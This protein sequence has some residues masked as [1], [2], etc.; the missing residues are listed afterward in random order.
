M[1]HPDLPLE[2]RDDDSGSV[3]EVL[4]IAFPLIMA[5]SSHALRLFSDRLMLSRFSQESLSASLSAGVM[6]FAS[7]CFFMGTASYAGTFVA[8]YTGAGRSG[9]VGASVWQGIYLALF[10]GLCLAM[11]STQAHAIFAWVGHSP[12]VQVQQVYY[13]RILASMAV[14]PLLTG[15]IMCFWSG[16]GR[17]WTIFLISSSGVAINIFF[18]WL[19]IFGNWGFPELGIR[20][21]AIATDISSVF[22]LCFALT[23][24]WAK[25]NRK[26][27]ET[28]PRKTF[29]WSLFSRLVRFGVP[30]GVNMFL[31]VAAFNIFVL[32]LGKHGLVEG[33]AT[34][35]AFSMN[36]M[37]FIP[38]IGIGM[39]VNI[40]VGQSIGADDIPHAKRSVRSA[41]KII[42]LYMG[43]MSGLFLLTPGWFVSLFNSGN[44]VRVMA[45]GFLRYIATYLVFDGFFIIYQNAI[46][47]AGDTK[48][49]MY[50]GVV[51]AWL[52]LVVPCLIL[53]S[54][55]YPIGYLWSVF[56]AY[57]ML[58]GTVFFMRYRC[59]KWENMKV[60]E[61]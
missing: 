46:K 21:A 33:A 34:A 40:L 53:Y 5:T 37:A 50:A 60:I 52:C 36:A 20:G 26:Q 30:N 25:S 54:Y 29:Q 10:G 4:R 58:A 28:F 49:S 47:G 32:I 56:V 59:G 24:F 27:F 44:E 3:G 6:T 42:S 51:I 31:D 57:I 39:T 61:N 15:A 16:R 14:F 41:I 13:F 43:V 17:T 45:T 1:K 12:L 18:N 11:L 48:F 38:M 55:D 23:L 9:R 35:I 7:M 19:L 22:A 8:Q 2:K